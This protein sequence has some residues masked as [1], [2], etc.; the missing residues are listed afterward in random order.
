MNNLFSDKEIVKIIADISVRNKLKRV[1]L[2][3]GS[4]NAPLSITFARDSRIETFVLVDERSAAFFALGL[5]QQSSEPVGLVCTSGTALLNYA[6]A[7]AEAYYQRIPLIVISADRPLEWI[8]Q[9]D[10]QAIRQQEAL[11][12]V[13]KGVFQLP[14]S[15]DHPDDAWYANRLINEAF[16]MALS[17]R[18]GPVHIN[19]PLREPLYKL[20]VYNEKDERSVQIIN[21][22]GRLSDKM[23]VTLADAIRSSEKV[24]ILAGLS[25]PLGELKATLERLSALPQVVVLTETVS[26]LNSS[27]FI[28]TIDRVITSFSEDEL[29]GF[30]PDLL[31]SFGGPI[32]SKIIRRMI[33]T[34]PP[35]RHWYIGK[36]EPLIDTFCHLTE[37]IDISPASFFSQ[38]EPL[39]T[40]SCSEYSQRWMHRDDEQT[41]KHEAFLRDAEWSDLKAFGIILSAIPAGSNLQLGNSATVRYSQ[42]FKD[43]D[44]GNIRGNRGTSGIDGSSS[45]AAGTSVLFHGITTLISG[46][47][48]LMYDSHAFWNPYLTARFKVI[49]IKNG[50]GGIFRFIPGPMDVEECEH[51]FETVQDID[52]E[53]LAALYRLKYFKAADAE[54][55]CKVLPLF[56]EEAG[57]PAIL[58]V[59]TPRTINDKVLKAYFK[60]LQNK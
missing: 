44:A 22:E 27:R 35:H 16:N 45:T 24:M 6:P 26:N 2:S 28:T 32:V 31:I 51:Y 43:C 15:A 10:S 19:V 30:M 60:S 21:S 3:P 48:S 20:K 54:S 56:Y 34:C 38:I 13:V 17:G 36:G 29:P 40:S 33:R 1:V 25:A 39:V 55:L 37:R 41:K 42:L 49:V 18:K 8:D 5:A 23:S 7:V 12:S 57:R 11:R 50:G 47:M 53:R 58:E 14:V 46:D 52:V 59:E 4:R 9:D